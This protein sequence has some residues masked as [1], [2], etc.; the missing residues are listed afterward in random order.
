MNM[1]GVD[2]TATPPARAIEHSPERSACMARCSD[3][4]RRGACG[5]HRHRR[6]LQAQGVGDPAGHQAAAPVVVAASGPM[7]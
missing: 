1:P 7:P 6:A 4:Q 2:I 3:D 5:V